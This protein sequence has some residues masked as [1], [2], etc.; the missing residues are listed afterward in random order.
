M[1]IE[2]MEG[3]IGILWVIRPPSDYNITQLQG[4]IST[5]TDKIQ[6]LTIPRAAD[7]Q[8]WCTGCYTKEHTVTKCPKLRGAGPPH[9][10]WG[11]HQ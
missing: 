11:L 6:E 1:K 4:Q 8:V 5:L 7:P 3:Y 9:Y 10:P 2:A